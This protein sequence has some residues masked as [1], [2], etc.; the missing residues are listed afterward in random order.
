[1]SERSSRNPSALIS[2][3]GVFREGTGT[4]AARKES[5]GPWPTALLSFI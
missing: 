3:G 2:D 1:M 4:H 5:Q